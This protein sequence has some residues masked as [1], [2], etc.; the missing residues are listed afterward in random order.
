MKIAIFCEGQSE[1]LFSEWLVKSMAGSKGVRF[2]RQQYA[3]GK[4]NE[5]RI[6]EI[7]GEK[8]PDNFS[9]FVLVYDCGS[10]SR[11]LSEIREQYESLLNSGYNLVLGLRDVFPILPENLSD[12]ER[13]TISLTPKGSLEAKVHFAKMEI[14]AWTLTAR[15]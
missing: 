3:G 6:I 5:K 2:T 14:E 10:D 15:G 1:S 8:P 7:E 13:T 11:V 9:I 4:R 12:L